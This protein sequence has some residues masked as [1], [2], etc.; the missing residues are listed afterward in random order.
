MASIRQQRLFCASRARRLKALHA[1][2]REDVAVAAT[3]A[4][5]S[6]KNIFGAFAAGFVGQRL[7]TP[8]AARVFRPLNRLRHLLGWNAV[9]VAA[10]LLRHWRTR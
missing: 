9:G 5:R 10:F 8:R 7:H 4:A 6:K 2:H 1:L 3:E